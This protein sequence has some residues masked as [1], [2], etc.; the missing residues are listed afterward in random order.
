MRN[1]CLFCDQFERGHP[2]TV[3]YVCSGCVQDLLSM[4]GSKRKQR[5][6]QARIKNNQRV[7]TALK[8]FEIR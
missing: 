6:Q 4:T 7:L 8:M 3:D 1:L 5:K 2:K